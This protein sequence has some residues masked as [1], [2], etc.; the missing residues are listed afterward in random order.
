MAT[1][2]LVGGAWLGAW[3]WRDVTPRLRSLGHDVYPATLTGLGDRVHLARRDV[4]L[5]THITDL[6]DLMAYEDLEQVFL[7]GHSYAG[8]VITGVGDRAPERLAALVY[9]DSGPL[10]DGMCMLDFNSPEGR[11]RL[12]EAVQH[13]GDGWL[14]PFPGV[15]G[16]DASVRGIDAAG[17]ALME[18]KATPQPFATWTTP[19][20]L[21]RSGP[22]SY[23]RIMIIC[24]DGKEMLTWAR[25]NPERS[26]V[27]DEV[28]KGRGW[29]L[30]ELDTG[31][32]PMLST[33]AELATLLSELVEP[34]AASE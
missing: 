33:P 13:K 21:R 15:D 6:L 24:D 23:R 11:A 32:W 19:L 3:A 4:D 8:S 2:V 30:R 34:S 22:P 17:R 25:A 1:F 10:A 29:E 16:L 20:R 31:H 14:V 9:C 26:P 27:M 18:R 12:L 5:E 28:L 7:V